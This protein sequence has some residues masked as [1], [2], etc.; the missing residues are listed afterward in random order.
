MKPLQILSMSR[1]KEPRHEVITLKSDTSHMILA[2]QRQKRQSTGS[3]PVRSPAISKRQIAD[4]DDLPASA[5]LDPA[6]P[7]PA[8][9]S[10]SIDPLQSD[11]MSASISVAVSCENFELFIV[12]ITIV[13][14]AALVLKLGERL[15][16]E[17]TREPLRG[18][19]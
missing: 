12:G 4:E 7:R 10:H 15:K 5:R 2:S 3:G 19:W 1:S 9:D 14:V 13:T 11:S 8:P 17:L 16:I 18:N 6:L